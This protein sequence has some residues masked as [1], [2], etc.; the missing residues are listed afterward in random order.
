M[1]A[2][3]DP[4]GVTHR[5]EHFRRHFA[6]VEQRSPCHLARIGWMIVAIESVTDHRANT[7]RADHELGFVSR[8]VG[9]S[10]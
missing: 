5:L 9:E 3:P 1:A 10:Q 2:W 6:G 7:V 4:L 8:A